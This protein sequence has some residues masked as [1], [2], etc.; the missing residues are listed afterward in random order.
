MKT[1]TT[2]S[3]K[4]P[5]AQKVGIV[6]YE[7]LRNGICYSKKGIKSIAFNP[8]DMEIR[9][10]LFGVF[11]GPRAEQ[12]SVQGVMPD[13]IVAV[14]KWDGNR[15]IYTIYK[16]GV[17]EDLSKIEKDQYWE[18]LYAKHPWLHD[19]ME[20]SPRG[21]VSI[22][23]TV[24]NP[25]DYV[26]MVKK[27]Q[28]LKDVFDRFGFTGDW[29]EY[30]SAKK[31]DLQTFPEPINKDIINLDTYVASITEDHDGTPLSYEE[32]Y[33]SSG[34][35]KPAVTLET[36]FDIVRIG[37]TTGFGNPPVLI[38]KGVPGVRGYHKW[39]FI[40]RVQHGIYTSEG[41]SH[42]VRVNIWINPDFKF[43]KPKQGD[44]TF[45]GK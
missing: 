24:I 8:K 14:C 16:W 45:Q 15:T 20:P 10:V 18:K 29:N 31:E 27:R 36:V 42:G 43:P 33:G 22:P 28:R 9:P 21:G 2:K 26:A 13:D 6:R 11:S 37:D 12:C 35:G 41:K 39:R 1:N 7:Q 30:R 4:N 38:A 23:E 3:S 34:N 44:P 40:I 5:G 32:W 25:D 17:S 19:F